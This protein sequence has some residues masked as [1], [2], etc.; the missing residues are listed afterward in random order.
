MMKLRLPPHL[1]FGK[2]LAVNT[3]AYG[4]WATDRGELIEVQE[5][6]HGRA[7][8][9]AISERDIPTTEV[10]E[11]INATDFAMMY[12]GWIRLANG[13]GEGGGDLEIECWRERISKRAFDTML[14]FLSQSSFISYSLDLRVN[15]PGRETGALYRE[16]A[17][18]QI[19]MLVAMLRK[20]VVRQVMPQVV[21]SARKRILAHAKRTGSKLAEHVLV[22]LMSHSR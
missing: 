20:N 22:Q 8:Q 10:P 3:D 13:N 18:D 5:M 7:A 1:R 6:K 16:F 21:V 9:R 17:D 11:G 15:D 14:K 4:W 19:N 12:M 2:T